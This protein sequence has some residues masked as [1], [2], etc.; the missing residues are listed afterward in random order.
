MSNT[1]KD[2]TSNLKIGLIFL[3]S[4]VTDQ[5]CVQNLSKVD[6]TSPCKRHD[7]WIVV[8]GNSYNI[9]IQV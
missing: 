5:G 6:A 3:K 8:A 7:K 9:N 4:K 2:N 1:P